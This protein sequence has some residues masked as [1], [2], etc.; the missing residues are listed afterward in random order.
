MKKNTKVYSFWS[1]KNVD[2]KSYIGDPI[3]IKETDKTDNNLIEYEVGSD[4]VSAD[5]LQK[6]FNYDQI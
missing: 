6:D 5:D 1:G 4:T 2:G 3:L